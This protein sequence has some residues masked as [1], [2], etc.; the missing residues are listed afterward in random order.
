MGLHLCPTLVNVFLF[1]YEKVCPNR[2]PP[3]FKSVVYRG[4]IR[5]IFVLFKSKKMNTFCQLHELER[6][7]Y[8]IYLGS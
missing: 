3:Q 2:C 6:Q 8:K 4:Y 1:H 7:E 5:N